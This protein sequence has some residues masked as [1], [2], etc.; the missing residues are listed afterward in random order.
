VWFI[1]W[2]ESLLFWRWNWGCRLNSSCMRTTHTNT[3]ST[4]III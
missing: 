2:K 1:F 3:S 4:K